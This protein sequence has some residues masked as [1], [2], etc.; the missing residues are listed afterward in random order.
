MSFGIIY[1]VGSFALRHSKNLPAHTRELKPGAKAN[2]Y[3]LVLIHAIQG[4]GN[5]KEKI[6]LTQTVE[7]KLICLETC[8]RN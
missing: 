7:V 8:W 1:L 5:H 2:Q 4:I 6:C 3:D